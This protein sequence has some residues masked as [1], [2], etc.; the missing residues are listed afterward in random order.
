MN[1]TNYTLRGV[2]TKKDRSIHLNGLLKFLVMIL[3]ATQSAAY[4]QPRQQ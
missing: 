1:E 3:I 4:K 2:T